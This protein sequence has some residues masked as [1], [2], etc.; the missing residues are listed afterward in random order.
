MI[1]ICD[2]DGTVADISHRLHF[3]RKEPKDWRGFFAACP[4]DQPILPV[5]LTIRALR[6]SGAQIVFVTGR[7]DEIRKETV[8]WLGKFQLVNR[9]ALFF[10]QQG[11]HREDKILK[12]EL[13]D[14]VLELFPAETIAG[15]FEDRK[16]VVEMYRSRGLTVF[17]VADGDY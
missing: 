11:D 4:Q 12:S 13:L 16:Q 1:Y 7:S 14:Q 5:I 17:Q 10:R 6:D 15:V 8:E 9:S 2:I 3:I